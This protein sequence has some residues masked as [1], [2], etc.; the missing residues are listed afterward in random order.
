MEVSGQLQASAT[1]PLGKAR[2]SLWVGGL[3][4][5]GVCQDAVN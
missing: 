1:Y 2:G 3:M 4:G 5:P